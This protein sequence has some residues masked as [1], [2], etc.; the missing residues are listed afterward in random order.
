MNETMTIAEDPSTA[1]RGTVRLTTAQALVRYLSGLRTRVEGPGGDE[2]VP[3]FGEYFAIFGHGNVAGL[4]EASTNIG[5][6]CQPFAHIMNRRW[7]TLR[8][9]TRKRTFDAG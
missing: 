7:R 4:G 9:L 5:T 8:S 3:L 2:V 1:K 6:S